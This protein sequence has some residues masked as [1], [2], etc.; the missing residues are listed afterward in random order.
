MV[1]QIQGDFNLALD[2]NENACPEV[3]LDRCA[4]KEIGTI[5]LLPVAAEKVFM[6]AALLP[7]TDKVL[8][9]GKNED[10]RQTRI[11]DADTGLV[12]QPANQPSDE[13]PA[14]WDLW[15]AG[16]AFLD[17]PEGHLLAHGGFAG[18]PLKL[19]K[20]NRARYAQP[21]VRQAPSVFPQ[22]WPWPWRI[23]HKPFLLYHNSSVTGPGI[24]Y[25]LLTP[26]CRHLR[27][28]WS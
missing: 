9:W 5:E 6:H 12:S 11:F 23:P 16:H 20:L 18:S 24:H 13:D 27:R 22:S 15:S 8:Y 17:T 1:E 7:N 4:N 19:P 25:R 14:N 10:D 28:P 26:S 21:G 2:D 3:D